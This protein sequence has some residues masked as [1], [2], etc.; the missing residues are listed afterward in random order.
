MWQG[1]VLRLA[2]C[3]LL[4]EVLLQLRHLSGCRLLEELGQADLLL[5]DLV[6]LE[7]LLL[8]L[9]RVHLGLV[10]DLLKNR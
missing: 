8:H 1:A 6:R 3:G 10:S 7:H 5:F 2:V 9:R 4:G